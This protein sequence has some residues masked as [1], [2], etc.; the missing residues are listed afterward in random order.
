MRRRISCLSVFDAFVQQLARRL[1]DE[2]VWRVVLPPGFDAYECMELLADAASEEADTPLYYPIDRAFRVDGKEAVLSEVVRLLRIQGGKLPE[3]AESL[4]V[5][6]SES[7]RSSR[8]VGLI[9]SDAMS[10]AARAEVIQVCEEIAEY[11]RGLKGKFNFILLQKY[12]SQPV[13]EDG[14]SRARG[15]ESGSIVWQPWTPQ[16]KPLRFES[17]FSSVSTSD[18]R[19]ER[20]G[21]ERYLG[22]RLYW[23]ASGAPEYMSQLAEVEELR[24]FWIS[25][26][27]ADQKIER[28]FDEILANA[29]GQP[30][31][32]SALFEECGEACGTRVLLSTGIIRACP[33]PLVQELLG[34]GVAWMPPNGL[35]LRVTSVA[36]RQ[37]LADATL[38]KKWD[39]SEQDALNFRIA[40]RKN[41]LLAGWVSSLTRLVELEML[42]CCK[43]APNLPEILARHQMSAELEDLCARAARYQSNPEPTE[44]IDHASFGQLQH[45]IFNSVLQESF[46]VSRMRIEE[47]RRTRNL[48]AHAH[49]VRWSGVR[50]LLQTLASLHAAGV[51]AR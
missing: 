19:L 22:L 37:L 7:F 28:K 45:L 23:E 38:R 50:V 48:V 9:L 51:Q 31:Q 27:D 13:R 43:Q 29:G 36:A 21:F 14:E 41:P 12:A 47:I 49:A 25:A 46:P 26:E 2:L 24:P 20:S 3:S 16:V 39:I 32:V 11:T 6:H 40:A 35:H 34:A 10:D 15:L 5:E 33:E 44:P 4:M 30:D 8:T 1:T 42:F 17:A 18:S